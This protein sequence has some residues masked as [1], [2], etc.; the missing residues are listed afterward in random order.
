MLFAAFASEYNASEPDYDQRDYNCR[1]DLKND[2]EAYDKIDGV[3]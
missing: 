1:V 3:D 2:I